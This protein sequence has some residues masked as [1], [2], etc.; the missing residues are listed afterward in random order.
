MIIDYVTIN[1]RCDKCG[2]TTF[3]RM[4]V[5]DIQNLEFLHRFTE[6][7]C[8]WFC[9]RCVNKR[10]DVDSFELGIKP[11]GVIDLG[12]RCE[13]CN[14]RWWTT[15][16]YAQL[17]EFKERFESLKT[18]TK[19]IISTCNSDKVVLTNTLHKGHQIIL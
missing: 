14:T 8:E 2:Y 16:H 5:K 19:C 7:L 9:I 13:T 18:S 15:E 1:M 12:W 10:L 3:S 17:H 4:Y 6:E 11:S